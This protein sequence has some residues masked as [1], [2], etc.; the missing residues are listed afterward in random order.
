[1]DTVIPGAL[2]D[3]LT[4]E[5]PLDLDT[6]AALDSAR[7][8][9]GRTLVF[10][11]RNITPLHVISRRAEA[12]LGDAYATDAQ[13]RAAR[14]WLAA[15][16]RAPQIITVRY[17]STE[18]AYD[19]SQCSA[20]V[21]N[22]DVLVVEAEQA[23]AFLYDAWP[24]AVTTAHGEFHGDGTAPTVE[25]AR[26]ASVRAAVDAAYAIGA[27]LA[28]AV[29]QADAEQALAEAAAADAPEAN[30]A[31]EQALAEA[32]LDTLA[33]TVACPQCNAPAGARCTTRAGKPARETHGRRFEAV[34]QAAGITAHRAAA[35]REAEAR[36][37][38]VVTHDR[39]AEAALLTTYAA[40][41]AEARLDRVV[42]DADDQFARVARAVD[43]V[44]HAEQV[45]AD[46]A[47]V[48]DAEAL[49]AV[50][51]VSEA[52]ATEGTWRGAWIG[53][54][55]A[56]DVLFVVDQAAEQGALFDTRATG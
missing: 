24:V 38:W 45:E 42:A 5:P 49:Y 4:T 51:L 1:M 29:D 55:Q 34:E 26:G 46:V 14:K 48:E 35:R 53:E 31:V 56:D 10:E 30:P 36:G 9:R 21:R 19:A 28:R 40:R 52:E 32:T 50:R 27:P 2:A 7:R 11:P 39:A 13:K 3:H 6:R 43:A 23:V 47:T 33:D 25:A 15:A 20:D 37:G 18:E 22:G 44:E 12:L 17:A 41:L 16:G 8:G 54:H